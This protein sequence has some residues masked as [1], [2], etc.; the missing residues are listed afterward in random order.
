MFD[1]PETNL[2]A[3]NKNNVHFED[4]P[5]QTFISN[6]EEIDV[7]YDVPYRFGRRKYENV[8]PQSLGSELFAAQTNLRKSNTCKYN[9]LQ[10]SCRICKSVDNLHH[11]VSNSCSQIYQSFDFGWDGNDMAEN[12]YESPRAGSCSIEVDAEVHA[13]EL[14]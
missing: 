5:L 8:N 12:Y 3:R 10:R 2:E 7:P 11:N 1:A 6:Y 9:P 13:K 4:V 14:N